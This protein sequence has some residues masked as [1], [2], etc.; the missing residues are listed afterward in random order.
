[1]NKT[2]QFNMD[3]QNFYSANRKH[4]DGLFRAAFREKKD[5][6]ELY[7]ALN[8]TDYQNPEELTVYTLED[9]VYISIKNDISFLF[10][11]MLNLYEHQSSQNPNMPMRGLLYFARNYESYIEQN[12]M[13]IYGS[14]LQ[15]FPLPQYYIFYNGTEFEPDRKEMEL[16]D[17]F[18]KI[19]GKEPCLNCKAV[20]LNINYGHNAE[21]MQK[22]KRLRDYA[23]F[24]HYIRK[25]QTNGMNLLQAT[26][27]AID[28]CIKKSILTDLLV[29][30][31][32]EVRDM[33]LTSFNKELYE[34]DLKAEGWEA[35]Y[36]AGEQLKLIQ[37]VCKKLQKNKSP[38]VI[39]EELEEELSTI[40]RICKTADE[41][42]L[43]Y[44]HDRIY[45]LL[46]KETL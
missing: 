38:E 21:L 42:G 29:K 5:L 28:D 24:I 9:V 43:P 4:K 6:L 30:Y 22:C 39:A 13:N 46:Q 44:D 31:R 34:R 26:D 25:N 1:M 19:K 3:D 2:K 11:E 23:I 16:A 37:L 40:Q 36:K 32:A 12:G 17:A 7:N 45:E 18:P 8:D 15:K 41:C 35:G 14:V 27:K 10:G 33:V 20:L